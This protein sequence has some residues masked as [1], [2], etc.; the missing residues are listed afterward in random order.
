[1]NEIHQYGRQLLQQKKT[2]EALDIFKINFQKHP[3]SLPR[4]G[5]S[6]RL[7]CEWRL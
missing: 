1:M 5:I 4:D 3:T 6:K 7:F 2:K